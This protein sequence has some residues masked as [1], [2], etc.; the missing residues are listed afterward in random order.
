MKKGCSGGTYLYEEFLQGNLEGRLL[1]LL[2]N[3][4]DEGFQRDA[5]CPI[6]RPPSP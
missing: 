4:K 1:P 2:G 5:K 6:N 3:P